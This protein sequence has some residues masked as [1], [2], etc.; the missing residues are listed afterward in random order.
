MINNN[1][2]DLIKYLHYI[3]II[4]V[5]TGHYITP[6]KYLKYYLLFVIFI[7]LDWNDFDGQ[8]ILTGIE[9]YFR[10]GKQDDRPAHEEN[11]PEF[12]RP[13]INNTFNINLSREES[14]KLNNFLFMFCFLLG[15][16]RLTNYFNI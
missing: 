12:F 14:K 5:F 8:C 13:L 16:L 10:Y 2:A 1:V 15:F 9:Y 7:F 6:I 4:Y 11:A 3:L